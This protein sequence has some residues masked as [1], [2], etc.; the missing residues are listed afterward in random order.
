MKSKTFLRKKSKRV[1]SSAFVEGPDM[2]YFLIKT[3]GCSFSALM[4]WSSK[5]Y[6]TFFKTIFTF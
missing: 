3:I 1:G 6:C 2:F 4:S 5:A